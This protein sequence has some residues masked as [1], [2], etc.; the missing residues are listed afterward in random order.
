MTPTWRCTTCLVAA[1]FADPDR[2]DPPVGWTEHADGWRCLACGRAHAITAALADA[3]VDAD[4]G[5]AA[6]AIRRRAVAEFELVRDPNRPDA[7]IAKAAGTFAAVVA[8]VRS[9]LLG[10]GVIAPRAKGAAAV[11][12]PTEPKPS[13]F[14]ALHGRIDAALRRDPSESNAAI[15]RRLNCTPAAVRG[16]RRRL[17]AAGEIGAVERRG[18]RREKAKR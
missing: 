6:T 18:G 14:A 5:K 11:A 8:S 9:D 17:E 7:M 12:R 1:S 16:R 4:A 3:G 10:A 2:A 15:G 13:R